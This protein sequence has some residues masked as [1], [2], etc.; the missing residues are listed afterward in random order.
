VFVDLRRVRAQRIEVIRLAASASLWPDPGGQA[1]AV[2]GLSERYDVM[3]KWV[4]ANVIPQGA[5]PEGAAVDLDALLIRLGLR[6]AR[7]P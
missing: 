7:S 6:P 1:Q 5:P 3:P 2:A 4:L